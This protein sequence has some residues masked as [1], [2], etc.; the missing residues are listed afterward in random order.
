MLR[1]P[2]RKPQK[3][4]R[5]GSD[6][7]W[8]PFARALETSLQRWPKTLAWTD[9]TRYLRFVLNTATAPQMLESMPTDKVADHR[10]GFPL[11][12]FT[13]RLNPQRRTACGLRVV[14]RSSRLG[15]TESTLNN[16]SRYVQVHPTG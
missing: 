9:S 13:M 11:I 10:R 6:W 16:A 8:K 15:A 12:H 14:T 1:W 2:S 4:K 5:D 7:R 3:V